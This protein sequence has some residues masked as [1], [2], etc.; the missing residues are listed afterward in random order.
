ME[1]CI[2]QISAPHAAFTPSLRARPPRF[3]TLEVT[4]AFT[5]VTARQLAHHPEGGFVDEL[6]SIGLPPLCHPSYRAL[7]LALVGLTPTE[8][9]SL[10]WAHKY[11]FS[12][13]ARK[14]RVSRTG[15]VVGSRVPMVGRWNRARNRGSFQ[16]PAKPPVQ[17]YSGRLV[18]IFTECD[19]LGLID[20]GKELSTPLVDVMTAQ[21]ETVTAEDSLYEVTRSMNQGGY[22][23]LPV[24]DFAGSPI[25]IVDVKT[26][27]H[28]LVEHFPAAVYNQVHHRHIS[29]LHPAWRQ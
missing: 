27:V 6:Q 20:G 11:V 19:L 4:Y 1:R 26:V 9:A 14:T 15:G 24:V 5:F 10:R 7:A 12:I 21:P 28:F 2:S 25:G 17:H 23:H 22:R 8:R 13:P 29:V 18:G 3:K 16:D